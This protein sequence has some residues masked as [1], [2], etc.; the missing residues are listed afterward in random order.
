MSRH[1]HR[2]LALYTS[3]AMLL[4]G[5]HP[6]QPFF[7]FEDGDLSHYVGLA[8]TID[9]PDVETCSL[10]E[11][12]HASEP[13]TL[14][15]H[16]HQEPWDLRLE[17]AVVIALENSKVMRN[18]GGRFAS[19]GGQRAQVGEAPETLQRGVQF[20]PTVYDPAIAESDPFVG[21]EGA[22]SAFDAQWNTSLFWENR[23]RP[24]NIAPVGIGDFIFAR[25]QRQHLATFRSGVTKRT[26]TGA[27]F[28]FENETIYDA[29]NSPIRDVPSDWFTAFTAGFRQ[30]LLQGAGTLY[31]RIAGPQDPFTGIGTPLF[32]GVVLARIRTDISL[33][34][35]E[36]GVRNLVADV[37]HA[38][39]ELYFAYR[40]LD[41]RKA[42]RDSALETWKK[43]HALYMEEARGGEADKE[44]Q[45]REQYFFFRSE[46]ENALADLYRAENRL[47][48]LMGIAASDGRLIRPADEPT[49]ANMVVDWHQVLQEGL[50]RSPEVRQQKWRIKQ[51]ELELIASKN[52][53]LPRLDAIGGYRFLGLGDQLLN[54]DGRAYD[55]I[56]NLAGT[57]AF[58]TLL[59]G[60]FQE[61]QFGFQG[62][63]PIGF[64]RELATV[65]NQQLLLARE[66]A[67]TQDLELELTHQLTEAV[68]NLDVFHTLS[69]TN[70]NRRVA[71]ERE[72]EAV[73]AAY[74]AGTVTLDLLLNAQRRR[75]D[76]EAAYYRSLVDY[77]RAIAQLHFRKGSLL[78]YNGVFL[79]EG[80]WPGK[81]YFDAHR[82]ARA[83]DA[84]YFLNYGFTR[85]AVFSRGPVAQFPHEHESVEVWEGV[86]TP[87]SPEMVPTPAA[88]EELPAAPGAMQGGQPQRRPTASGP[89]LGSAGN[90]P[91]R[92]EAVQW[93]SYFAETEEAEAVTDAK[94]A[95][96][97]QAVDKP[98][99][100][101]VPAAPQPEL[102]PKSDRLEQT[103]AASSADTGG[104]AAGWKRARR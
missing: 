64:R 77:N 30:P 28:S 18:L 21:V 49:T 92:D 54:S 23:D 44:A 38:Y 60:N 82:R 43:I 98:A 83:R 24:Q 95:A 89:Q 62:S 1:L 76:A 34:D 87:A 81:A 59:H 25:V 79:A 96:A 40:N 4:S 11:V 33:V 84:A 5:C 72:V 31:N 94:P 17:D 6:R 35:F 45:A 13:L 14:S 70:L 47:R 88:T 100:I 10:S 85:P 50:V 91:R 15:R 102:R 36:I 19:G 63:I 67:L 9:Y 103:S 80:P 29:N 104:A 73:Q 41:A 48:Y 75:A 56:N 53:L 66:R 2:L 42:G 101:A 32:D 65:R 74:D 7:F 46:V 61:W 37:E 57:D 22:L 68:R 51:R 99:R 3:A 86:P 12:E 27:Q 58:S 20:T 26:A 39:W 8:T 16:A 78:E 71:S 55:G 52:L 69:Q 90:Q 97:D 93:A